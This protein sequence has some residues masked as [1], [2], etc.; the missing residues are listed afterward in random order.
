MFKASTRDSDL[1]TLNGSKEVNK[2]KSRD[3]K[4]TKRKLIFFSF[5]FNQSETD[6]I[7]CTGSQ[8]PKSRG[9]VSNFANLSRAAAVKSTL[10]TFSAGKTTELV[11]K[12]HLQ[13]GPIQDVLNQVTLKLEV[14]HEK[15]FVKYS[16][17]FVA[18][19]EEK[20]SQINEKWEKSEEKKSSVES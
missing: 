12:W 18:H 19:V 5:Y 14:V 4:Y 7:Y 16:G 17:V 11:S 2:K 15:Q 10:D 13:K 20:L 3:E 9:V 8:R 1:K 6:T